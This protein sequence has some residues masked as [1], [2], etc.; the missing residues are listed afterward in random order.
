MDFQQ[1]PEIYENAVPQLQDLP[2]RHRLRLFLSD[3]AG[4]LISGVLLAVLIGLRVYHCK[5]RVTAKPPGE[6]LRS[7]LDRRINS[8]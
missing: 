4:L 7:L 1:H 5:H 2:F 6:M 8:V 3:S